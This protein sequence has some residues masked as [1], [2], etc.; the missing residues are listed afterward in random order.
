MLNEFS[1]VKKNKYKQ[2][3]VESEPCLI[4]IMKISE[5]EWLAKPYLIM[6]EQYMD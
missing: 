4:R 1:D 6:E 5:G 3:W 2:F